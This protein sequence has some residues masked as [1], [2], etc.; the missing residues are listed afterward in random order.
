M[1][2]AFLDPARRCC[3][4]GRRLLNEAELLEFERPPATRYY[5]SIIAQEEYAKAFLLY[6]VSIDAISWTPLILRATRNHQSKQLVG[7]VLDYISPDTAEFLRRIDTW[8]REKKGLDLPASVVDAMN[9]FRHEKIRRWESNTWVW[10][11]DPNYDKTAVSVAEGKRDME[12]QRALY[13]E[14]TKIGEV[15]ATP[16]Q[17]TEQQADDEYERGRRFDSCVCGLVCGEATGA[18][19]YERVEHCFKLLFS[20]ASAFLESRPS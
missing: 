10:A 16:E 9:I 14:L 17:V 2:Q 19:N 6:L 18:W 1:K 5:L 12:K 13:V 11:E 7:I 3:D 4:N 15:S 20:E 8:M